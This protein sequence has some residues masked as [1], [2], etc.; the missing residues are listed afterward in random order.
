MSTI[1]KK[2][3]IW[4][5]GKV[6]QHIYNL[7]NSTKGITV[8]GF[9]DNNKQLQNQYINNLPIMDINTINIDFDYF[10]IGSHKYEEE[11]YE[12]LIKNTKKPVFRNVNEL[13]YK[14][15]SIDISGWCNAKCKWCSTG[16]KNLMIKSTP[17]FMC[18]KDFK[19]IYE[20]LKKINLLHSF[21]EILLYSWGEPF[22]NPDYEEI[23]KYLYHNKQTFSLS[24]NASV[25]KYFNDNKD[26]YKYC[27]TVV[28]SMPGFS[29]SS[30]NKIH[31]FNFEIIKEN[32]RNL[33]NNMRL[34]GFEGEAY[35][36]Y[37]VY[38]FNELELKEAEKFAEELGIG[39]RPIKAYFATYELAEKYLEK[40]LP[41]EILIEVDNEL[42]LEHVEDLIS[43]RPEKYNCV[44]ENMVSIHW[45]G[46]IEL[47][48]CC[49]DSVESF[50][51]DSIL[52]INSLEE[53][54]LYR[55]KMIESKTCSKCRN[56]GIDYWFFNNPQYGE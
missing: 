54:R 4:G 13:I 17:R 30:Y 33:L 53:W 19:E 47:C 34:H 8:V 52:D 45:D 44:V 9:C 14:R 7:L 51:W 22:L 28:L 10:V 35:I 23:I 3:I 36:S 16:R 24:T 46:K 41:K 20:H 25:P 42:F 12:K 18:I 21:N 31:G 50:F 55:K 15:F 38:R 2:C 1:D 6:G 56:L 32:I 37:H 40:S 11:I 43:E 29:Q 49:D 48:C 5:A 26:Y 39:I 27:K